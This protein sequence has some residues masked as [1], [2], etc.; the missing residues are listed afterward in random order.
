VSR[1]DLE[2]FPEGGFQAD[3][4]LGREEALRSITIWA[5][6]GS[7]DE[8]RLGSLEVGKKADFVIL[9]RDLMVVP[10]REVPDAEVLKTFINGELVF[11]MEQFHQ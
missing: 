11:D 10:I 6:M 5:A 8:N 4:A 7:F 2:G 1:Q 9:D 3:N